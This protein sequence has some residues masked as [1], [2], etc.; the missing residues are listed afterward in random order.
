VPRDTQEASVK[1]LWILLAIVFYLEGGIIGTN[2][3]LYFAGTPSAALA[4]GATFSAL[5]VVRLALIGYQAMKDLK[6]SGV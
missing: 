4:W 1:R 3:H 2:R 6:I 5:E